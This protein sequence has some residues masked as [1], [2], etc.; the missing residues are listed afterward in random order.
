MFR[1]R[2]LPRLLVRRDCDATCCIGRLASSRLLLSAL[3]G[4]SCPLDHPIDRQVFLRN[5]LRR[6]PRP[7]VEHKMLCLLCHRQANTASGFGVDLGEYLKGA[8]AGED[9]PTERVYLAARGGTS[10]PPARLLAGL[11][12]LPF[13]VLVTTVGD[14]PIR[15]NIN[16]FLPER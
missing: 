5:L 15:H 3:C 4:A 14:A 11:F 7:G 2:G 9:Q 13:Q 6:R 1:Y 12:E 10:H 8:S 16:V